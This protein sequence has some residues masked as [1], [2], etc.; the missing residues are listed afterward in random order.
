[1]S[2]IKTLDFLTELIDAMATTKDLRMLKNLEDGKD[3][4]IPNKS[5]R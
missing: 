3:F 2:L 5:W 1:M 4:T